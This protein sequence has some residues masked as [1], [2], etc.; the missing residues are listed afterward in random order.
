MEEAELDERAVPRAVERA[1]VL[2]LPM[3][4]VVFAES[5]FLSFGTAIMRECCSNRSAMAPTTAYSIA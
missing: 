1:V 5:I 4:D 2:V 3:R